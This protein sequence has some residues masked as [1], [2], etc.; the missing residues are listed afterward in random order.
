MKKYLSDALIT[1]FIGFI[2][3]LIAGGLICISRLILGD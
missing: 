3:G 2:L 1:F